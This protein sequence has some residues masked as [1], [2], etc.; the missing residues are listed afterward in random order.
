MWVSRRLTTL[1]ASTACYKDNCTFFCWIQ[2]FIE[3]GLSGTELWLVTNRQTHM[4]GLI[5]NCGGRQ[6][7]AMTVHTQTGVWQKTDTEISEIISAFSGCCSWI[8]CI[9]V[10]LSLSL[11]HTQR[12]ACSRARATFMR[13]S[14][15]SADGADHIKSTVSPHWPITVTARS[16][17]WT[18]FAL[19]NTRIVGSNPTQGMNVCVYSVFVSCGGLATGWSP[20]HGVLPY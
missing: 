7:P 10:L 8:I 16:K 15:N 20:V 14:D 18:I 11:S 13:C 3:I 2:N 6:N 5:D 19:T 9:P 12:H 17:V 4:N 1:W